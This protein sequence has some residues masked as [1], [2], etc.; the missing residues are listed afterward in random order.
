VN[1]LEEKED[2]DGTWRRYVNDRLSDDYRELFEQLDTLV[3]LRIPSFDK[4]IEWRGLQE[5]KLRESAIRTESEK[6]D[7][8][9]F[10]MY[11]ERLTRHMLKT[12]PD[13][14]DIIIDVDH[15]HRLILAN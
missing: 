4:V 5:R 14:A 11:Y 2:V 9:R 3:M 1:K 6:L 10:V 8:E 7:L 13:Y 15:Q 12:M